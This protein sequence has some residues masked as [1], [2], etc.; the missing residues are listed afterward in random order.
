MLNRQKALLYLID[1]AGGETTPLHLVKWAFLLRE[2]SASKGGAS[3]YEFVPYKFG[4]YS[5]CIAQ[6]MNAMA[7]Q[8]YL[9]IE[10]KAG[11]TVWRITASGKTVGKGTPKPVA[12]DAR[13]IHWRYGKMTTDA[14]LDDIYPRYSWFTV[15]SQRKKLAKKK[16]VQP[17]VFTAGYEGVTVDGFLDALLRAGIER[18]IDVR[19]NPVSRRYGFHK[20]TLNRLA[21][22]VGIEYVHVPELGIHSENR[23]ELESQADYDAL[24]NVYRAKT[25]KR[26]GEAIRLVSK[27]VEG[28]PSVLVCMEANPCQCH[29]SHLAAAVAEETALPIKHLRA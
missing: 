27:L 20:S 3:F 7:E 17:A 10:E 19:N 4:P 12:Q 18:I 9:Q 28:K 24:F 6:E 2:E 23:Q 29:R 22:N 13:Q 8:G 5:F 26:E 16:T 11:H 15:N 21:G 25:L 14:L 1:L